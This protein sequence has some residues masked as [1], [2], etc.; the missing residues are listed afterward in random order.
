MATI[1]GDGGANKLSGGSFGDRISGLGG[2]DT[3]FGRFGPDTVKGGAGGDHVSGGEGADN[4][5]GEGGNDLVF[6][7]GQGD[8]NAGSADIAL[9]AFPGTFAR[10][11][12]ATAAPGD[13]DRLYV[14]EQHTGRIEILDT[15][16][17]QTKAT[18]FLDLPDGSLASGA[19]QGLLGLAFDPGYAS[20]GR[21]LVYA[22][23]AGG[24]IEVRSYQRSATNPDRAAAGSGDVILR[25]DRDNGDTHHNGGWMDFGPDGNLYIA[26]GDEGLSGDPANNAQNT[27]VLWGKILRV[28]V[29]GDDFP[30]NA[31]RDYAIPEGNP[32]AAG[33][34]ADEIWG[35]GL[36][37]PWR[38][39]FD[40]ETGDLYIGD[41]GQGEE[42]EIDFQE[43][44]TAGGANYGW[45]V[46]EGRL[47]FDD[48]VPSNPDPDSPALTDP[49]ASYS[50]DPAT[51]GFAVIGGYVYRG[52]GDGMEGRYLYADNITNQ[53]WGLR[54]AEG[55]AVDVTNH[56]E[57]VIG[58]ASFS[59]VTSFAEDGRGN[60]YTIGLGG[61]V[62]RLS[63]GAG[64]GD[65]ADTISGGAGNDTLYGGA[66]RDV[67]DGGADCDALFGGAQA[68]SLT[69]GVGNDALAGGAGDDLLDGG[70]GADV[71]TGGGGA[72]TFRFAPGG[73]TDTVADFT[74]DVDT[75]RLADAFG[76]AS[77]AEAL[78]AAD[79]AG[80][81]V[82][83][84]FA[85]GD[86][87]RVAGIT[88][89]AL[90]DDIVV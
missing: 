51:G 86:A 81:D 12:F 14:V 76:F 69:G 42:E 18:A 82:V 87:L 45:K 79:Q 30:G 59:R 10:P 21:F 39:S 36:R 37:N 66:G 16:T 25:I 32:F 41:V 88:I 83:F 54:M 55:R 4:L 3:L 48:S 80:A 7:C 84:D 5:A 27:G 74:D 31:T 8:R 60:L 57:Q 73:G 23:V 52:P 61:E 26:V 72:D 50:H 46:K 19:E 11:V 68:D 65:G 63:F 15:R 49:V 47:V 20:N 89:S 58:P 67:I 62:A 70:A 6:G 24:D 29:H 75:L 71:L 64:A 28:D 34:G 53:L 17:G 9:E 33:A 78:E 13:P 2:A 90:A 22:T 85:S 1:V 40:R 77:A 43:A 44:G 38:A 35:L 56:T